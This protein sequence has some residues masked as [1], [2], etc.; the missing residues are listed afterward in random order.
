MEETHCHIIHTD[1][2]HFSLL[3]TLAISLPG[4][5]YRLP[6]HTTQTVSAETMPGAHYIT[7]SI[8]MK[9]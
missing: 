6:A 2:L 8:H 3:P 5:K 1:M 4:M 7:D 9:S